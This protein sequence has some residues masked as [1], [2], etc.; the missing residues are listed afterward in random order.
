[1]NIVIPSFIKDILNVN[2]STNEML[3][4][5]ANQIIRGGGAAGTLP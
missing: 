1:M 3:K 5:L 4:C 2:S